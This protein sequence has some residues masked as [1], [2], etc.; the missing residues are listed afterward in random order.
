[1]GQRSIPLLTALLDLK[2]PHEPRRA[3]HSPTDLQGELQG[4]GA[5]TAPQQEW[6]LVLLSATWNFI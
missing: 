4:P 6:E 1:V 2:E 5:D 3:P